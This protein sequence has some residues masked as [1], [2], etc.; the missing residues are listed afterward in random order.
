MFFPS[1]WIDLH[2][3]TLTYMI[4]EATDPLGPIPDHHVDLQRLQEHRVTCSVW[5]A[6]V[7]EAFT[8]NAATAK[9]V[10]MI[11][12]GLNL[13]DQSLGQMTLVKNR[14]DF[15]QVLETGGTGIILGMEGATP[16]QDSFELFELFHMMGV[17][18]L[19]LTWNHNNHF[20]T[21]CRLDGG[22]DDGLTR[23]GEQLLERMA[24]LG[25]VI[26]LS[27][28]SPR[29]FE[30]AIENAAGPVMVSHAN[31]RQLCDH[32]RNLTDQQ[33][34]LLAEA[35][36]VLGISVCPHFLSDQADTADVETIADHVE[37]A[38]CQMGEDAVALGTDFDGITSL[39]RGIDGVESLNSIAQTLSG[40][41]HSDDK[42][43]KFTWRNASQLM[44]AGLPEK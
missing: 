38:W 9:A 11:N 28:A 26:D 19:T 37:Y 29:T 16:L 22:N 6:W 20:A 10:Q 13:V 41:G 35:G 21:A 33:M 36:G 4:D 17:R 24:A 32:R 25:M 27:H 23:A 3:D 40:R 18:V 44:R 30:Q 31:C 2:I 8:G 15:D 12:A 14:S 42:I 1:R 7:Q 5:A 39:P 43:E 34:T